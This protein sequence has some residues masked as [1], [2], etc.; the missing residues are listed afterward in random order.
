VER[1]TKATVAARAGVSKNTVSLAFRHD[2]SIPE[3]TQ[4]RVEK[5]ARALG[6]SKNPIVAQLMTELRRGTPASYRRTF[7]LL[8]AF[9]D[10]EALTQHWTIPSYVEGLRRR[11]NALGYRF[12]DFWLH[13]PELNGTRLD[14]ILRA[15]GI[16]GAIVVGLFFENELPHR[17]DNIWRDTGRAADPA[18]RCEDLG[19]GVGQTRAAR[20]GLDSPRTQSRH[21]GLGGHEPANDIA[22][23]AALDMLVSML[24]SNESGEPEFPRATLIGASWVPGATVRRQG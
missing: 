15:R 1:V 14:R 9:R 10:R 6:Y 4:T 5:V 17:F 22:A 11:G 23:E 18:S 2:P 24:H 3:A 7:A 16:R 20:C 8:N 12:D 13:D 21:P 19:R